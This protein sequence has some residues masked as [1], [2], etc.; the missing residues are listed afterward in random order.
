MFTFDLLIFILVGLIVIAFTEK[1]HT[2]IPRSLFFLIAGVV[3]S[4]FGIVE[5]VG[6]V[7]I[8]AGIAIVFLL[9]TAELPHGNVVHFFRAVAHNIRI[10]IIAAIG[11]WVGAFTFSTFFGWSFEEA[12]ILGAVFTA[13]ALAF[14]LGVLRSLKLE[15]T[16]AAKSAVTA[17]ATDAV[18]AG[19]IGMLTS[20]VVGSTITHSGSEHANPFLEIFLIFLF[21]GFLYLL[22]IFFVKLRPLRL[23]PPHPLIL[24][25]VG[26]IIIYIGGQFFGI[27]YAIGAL[28]AGVLLHEEIFAAKDARSFST[29]AEQIGTASRYIGPFFFIFLG[30]HLSLTNVIE[31]PLIIG[32]SIGLFLSV[33]TLQFATASFAGAWRGLNHRNATVLGFAMLPR[34]I[35]AIV[36]LEMNKEFISNDMIVP[37]VVMTIFFLNIATALGLSWCKKHYWH[38][39]K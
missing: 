4:T 27:H 28:L 2:L 39:E 17:A 11:P 30:L 7:E 6:A 33:A 31:Q 5:P 8:I 9:F 36:V 38:D 26:G 14:T 10:A 3:L 19:M 34:D 32:A 23:L 29:A 35:V 20:I 15:R 21:F 1:L 13:T 12:I 37:V 22:H 25:L 24:M 18:I 16:D